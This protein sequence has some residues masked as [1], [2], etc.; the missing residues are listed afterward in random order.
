MYRIV[1]GI[2]KIDKQN[3]VMMEEESRQMRG[4]TLKEDQKESV[5]KGH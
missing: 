3:L 5:S 4:Q 2:E 1:Y